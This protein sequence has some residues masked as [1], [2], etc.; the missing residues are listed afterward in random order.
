MELKD[1]PVELTE[2]REQIECNFIFCLWKEPE[3]IDDY[4]NV[5]NGTDIL[6]VDGIF[7]YGLC[8]QMY[9]AGYKVFDNISVVTFLADKPALQKGFDERT[10]FAP[11][12][13]I[14]ELLDSSNIDTYYSALVKSNMVLNLYNSGFNVQK[15]WKK[16]QQMN[17]D[18]LYDFYDYKLNNICVGKIDKLKAVDMKS[19]YE[20]FVE[21]WDRGESVGFKV[22]Y[23]L[24]N[25]TLAG[26]HRKNL[27]LHLAHIGKGKTTTAINMYIFP[28]IEEGENV[29]I[30]SNEQQEEEWRQMLLAT[31]VFNHTKK[32][33]DKLNRQKFVV[34][35]FTQEDKERI[36]EG[37]KWIQNQKGQL[38]LISLNDYSIDR[39]KKI[40]KKYSKIGFTEFIFDTLKPL[41]ENSDKAW[42]EFSEMAKQL[43]LISKKEDVA[44]IATAQLSSESMS[45]RF[46]DLSCTGKGK[47]IAE[48]ASTVVMFRELT[49]QEKEK[50]HAYQFMKGESGK[51]LSTKKEISLDPNKNYIVFFVPKNRFGSTNYQILYERNMSFNTMKEI[52]Y[53]DIPYDG[54][55]I[56]K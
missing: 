2:N 14:T 42:A 35:H 23:P 10:G 19:G 36:S 4:K 20:P 51:Y 34:G 27:L 28:A 38:I 18:E 54:F 44:V 15:D 53:I 43:F 7:Y 50:G 48:T 25:Y 55:K 22:G 30:I 3:L 5:V 1:Y 45:R 39:V 37:E 41:H 31:G 29:C 24:M 56:K 16:I 47:A 26:V 52:G 6:T 33:G 49:T 46:L 13:E 11:I 21:Q 8:Q 9:K 40:I 17:P 32:D 12:K